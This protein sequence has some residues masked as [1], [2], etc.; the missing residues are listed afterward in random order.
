MSMLRTLITIVLLGAAVV[1]Q[2]AEGLITLKSPHSAMA[3]MDRLEDTVKAR[4]LTV[5]ARIDHAAGADKIGKSLRPTVVLIFGN[6]QGGT[7]FMECAQSTGI[8]LPLKALVWEDASGQVWLAY[9]DPSYLATRHQVPDCTVAA[10]IAKALA[11]V[12]AFVVA[13]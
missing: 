5:F 3:T 8:D 6:P 2:A 12:S 11:G 10:N 13:P 1:T 9:N 4:G 7:P